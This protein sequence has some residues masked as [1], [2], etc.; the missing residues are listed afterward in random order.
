MSRSRWNTSTR[1]SRREFG[2]LT[3]S[4]QE[5]RSQLRNRDHLQFHV[6]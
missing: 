2:V 4:A 3:V 1:L 6:P 5:E